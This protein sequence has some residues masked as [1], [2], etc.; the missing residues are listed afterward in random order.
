MGEEVLER[1]VEGLEDGEDRLE[2]VEDGFEEGGE[3]G[4]G[5]M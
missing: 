1:R 2:K 3:G 4:G 5:W